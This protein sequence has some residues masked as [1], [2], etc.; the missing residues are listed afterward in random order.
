[1]LRLLVGVRFISMLSM[2]RGVY[3]FCFFA[4]YFIIIGVR[5]VYI[6]IYMICVV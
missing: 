1:M 3:G 2:I 5:S 6:Y 4:I